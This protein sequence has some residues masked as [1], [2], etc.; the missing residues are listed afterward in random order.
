MCNFRDN[1]FCSRCKVGGVRLHNDAGG[2]GA[3]LGARAYAVGSSVGRGCQG[4]PVVVAEFYDHEIAGD[5]GVGDCGEAVSVA[6]RACG[7]AGDGDGAIYDDYAIEGVG[8]ADAPAWEVLMRS[9]E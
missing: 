5:D 6:A 4:G 8:D 9:E 7:A 3:C 2:C 1:D